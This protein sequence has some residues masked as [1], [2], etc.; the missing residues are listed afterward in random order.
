MTST[1]PTSSGSSGSSTK[2]DCTRAGQNVWLVKVPKYLA[3]VWNQADASGIVGSL[4]IPKNSGPNN[5]SF[6]LAPHLTKLGGR[7]IPVPE[8]HKFVMSDFRQ[9]MGV[10]SETPP[11]EEEAS[12]STRDKI[13]FEGTISKRVD[14]RPIGNP[15]YMKMKMKDIEK[16]LK[17]K[18]KAI[19]MTEAIQSFRPNSEHVSSYEPEKKRSADKRVRSEREVV[20]DTIFSA[21]EKH[22]YYTLKDLIGITQ[23]PVTHLKS[24]L[25]DV[26]NYN[27]KN[28]HKNT[29]ELKPEYRH[30]RNDEKSSD[31]G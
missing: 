10:F 18:R 13:A 17:P 29:Y 3:D 16:A 26:C 7:E 21:F 19:L 15:N 28:P 4:R 11:D 22:Q 30:Y 5:V 27:L 9:T 23:Q 20:L 6:H 14:C 12:E 25:R 2:V 8:K 31:S 24:I 1:T